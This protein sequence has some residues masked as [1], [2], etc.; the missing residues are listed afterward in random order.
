MSHSGVTKVAV[1]GIVSLATLALVSCT[2]DGTGGEY[3]ASANVAERR[4]EL[5]PW[6][7]IEPFPLRLAE[8]SR[9]MIEAFGERELLACLATYFP[10]DPQYPPATLMF[11]E[12]DVE[13]DDRSAS[14]G[15]VIKGAGMAY[16][17]L[18]VMDWAD[19]SLALVRCSGEAPVVFVT[20][21]RL[22]DSSSNASDDF[23]KMCRQ[24]ALVDL[25]E[26]LDRP[27]QRAALD[28]LNARYQEW[29]SSGVDSR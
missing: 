27:K 8:Y 23:R 16:A 24:N 14:D 20:L 12:P 19:P 26:K 21:T 10:D 18:R 15:L 5:I 11:D 4:T 29:R 3:P 13:Y 7:A 1:V 6:P 2:T 28:Q 25:L 9:Q 17:T 22:F